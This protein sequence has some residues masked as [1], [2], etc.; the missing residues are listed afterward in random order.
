MLQCIASNGFVSKPGL[1]LYTHAKILSSFLHL[2]L[3]LYFL[4]MIIISFTISSVFIFTSANAVTNNESYVFLKKWGYQGTGNSQFVNPLAI[5]VDSVGNVYVGDS[6][7]FNIQKFDSD[8]KFISKWST[9][10]SVTGE[11]SSSSNPTGIAVDAKS[12]NLYI[13]DI[14]NNQVKVLEQSTS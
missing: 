4:F 12:G 2:T 6:G 13:D 14:T 9:K 1:I 5:A 8:G 7:N 10:S 11:S 3:C